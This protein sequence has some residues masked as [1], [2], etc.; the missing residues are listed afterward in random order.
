VVKNRFGFALQT[1][2]A[3][4]VYRRPWPIGVDRLIPVP[5]TASPTSPPSVP[6]RAKADGYGASS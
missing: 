6:S 2:L 4:I 5:I 3:E 1:R